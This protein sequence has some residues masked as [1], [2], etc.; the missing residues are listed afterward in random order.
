MRSS[1]GGFGKFLV[2]LFRKESQLEPIQQAKAGLDIDYSLY[3]VEAAEW[4]M[5]NAGAT[6][7]D[8][9]QE[10]REVIRQA[11][12]EFV[13]KPGFT[14]GHVMKL[15]SKHFD[16]EKAQLILQRKVG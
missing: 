1:K 2:G 8:L 16:D 10:Q 11:V 4:A 7:P 12:A 14:V 6:Y 5:Q 15:L 9:N 3:N 13:K